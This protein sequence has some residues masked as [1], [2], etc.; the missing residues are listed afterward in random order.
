MTL[1]QRPTL[2]LPERIRSVPPVLAAVVVAAV[3][4]LLWWQF[5]ATSGGDIVDIAQ[6]GE[7]QLRRGDNIPVSRPFSLSEARLSLT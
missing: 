6:Y 5:L 1:V 2:V 3:L 4:H 7:L